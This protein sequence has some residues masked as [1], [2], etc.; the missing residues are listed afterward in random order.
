M[1]K[2]L[3]AVMGA[4][5]IVAAAMAYPVATHVPEHSP[6]AAVAGYR[7]AQVPQP[8]SRGDVVDV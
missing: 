6:S 4:L 5:S 3:V 8:G 1:R 7:Q 2:I